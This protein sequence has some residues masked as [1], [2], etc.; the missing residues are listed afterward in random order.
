MLTHEQYERAVI[1]ARSRLERGDELESVLDFLREAGFSLIDTIK[2]VMSLK[3]Y[4]LAQ[5]KELVHF[6]DTWADTR[7]EHEELHERIVRDLTKSD[8]D[9]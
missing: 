4:P 3:S 2:A 5:A 7:E 1:D 6:S 9:G 8:E